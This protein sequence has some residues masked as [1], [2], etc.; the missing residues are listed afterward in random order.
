[1]LMKKKIQRE[2]EVTDGGRG[3]IIKEIIREE[4]KDSGIQ[5][6]V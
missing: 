2:G 1:M 3:E 5:K 4:V 6:S